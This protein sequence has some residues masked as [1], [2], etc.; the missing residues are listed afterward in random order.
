M[1]CV[2]VLDLDLYVISVNQEGMGRSANEKSEEFLG[3]PSISYSIVRI[4]KVFG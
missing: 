4:E 2:D 1:G 3:I